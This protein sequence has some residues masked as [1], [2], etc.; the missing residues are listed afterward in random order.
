MSAK[1]TGANLIAARAAVKE[2]QGILVLAIKA[3]FPVGATC[4]YRGACN[5]TWR[6]A[7]VYQHGYDGD[8]RIQLASG[9][10][11]WVRGASEKQAHAVITI[12]E[13]HEQVINSVECGHSV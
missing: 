4:Q 3:H 6:N 7:H 8:V 13:T 2:W 9:R 11:V 10:L 1:E 5:Q 12:G